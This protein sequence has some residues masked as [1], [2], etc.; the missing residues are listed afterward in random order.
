[1]GNKL[2]IAVI[3]L[4][5][6]LVGVLAYINRPDVEGY[7][8]ANFTVTYGDETTTL[9]LAALQQLNQSQFTK[10][11]RSSG[12]EPVDNTYTGVP[13]STVLQ[14]TDADILQGVEVVTVKAIDGYT[15]AFPV[16][17]V[18]REEHL[19]LVWERDGE[20]LGTKDSGGSGPLLVIPR[21]DEFG[22]RWCKFAVEAEVR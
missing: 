9:D 8:D 2:L 12:K 15:V 10:T 6:V 18:L 17:E 11:L 21:Q 14:A 1:M 20:P 7:E 4:L 22:Q 5:V 13:L 19:Y 3:V 16:E